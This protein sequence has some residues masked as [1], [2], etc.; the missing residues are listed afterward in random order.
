MDIR[1]GAA[2][3]QDLGVRT[4]RVVYRKYDDSL[5]W[6]LTMDHLGE[7]EHGVWA[8][9]R[10]GGIMRKGDAAPV[11]HARAHVVLLPALTGGRRG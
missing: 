7:D 8:G 1:P 6:H 2:S 9:Q 5:H 10:A 11:I 4:I 3:R